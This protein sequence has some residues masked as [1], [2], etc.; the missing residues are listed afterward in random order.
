L[1]KSHF[2]DFGEKSFRG[3][4]VRRNVGKRSTRNRPYFLL[5]F[6]TAQFLNEFWRKMG[7]APFWAI[8]LQTILVTLLTS[9]LKSRSF[10]RQITSYASRTSSV[11]NHDFDK[12]KKSS[13]HLY[14]KH[15]LQID[16]IHAY[17]HT[18]M[19][20]HCQNHP[21]NPFVANLTN[22]VCTY[23]HSQQLCLLYTV[24]VIPTPLIMATGSGSLSNLD[25]VLSLFYHL[26]IN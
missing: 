7:W 9:R 21:Y 17:V 1:G 23:I 6:S 4:V 15:C 5:F 11:V 20:F 13:L 18:Y 22:Y 24:S 2:A 12:N 19:F 8:F 25:Y 16:Y 3:K 10:S 14:T 26:C